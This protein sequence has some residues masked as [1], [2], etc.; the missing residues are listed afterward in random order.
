MLFETLTSEK[1]WDL[2]T[3]RADTKSLVGALSLRRAALGS[4]PDSWS[5]VALSSPPITSQHTQRCAF[6]R[7]GLLPAWQSIG[8]ASPP[9]HAGIQIVRPRAPSG[10]ESFEMCSSYIRPPPNL[11]VTNGLRE[12]ITSA[13]MGEREAKT[14][15]ERGQTFF[16][17]RGVTFSPRPSDRS[18][19]LARPLFFIDYSLNA[20][21]CWLMGLYH[22]RHGLEHVLAVDQPGR[23]SRARRDGPSSRWRADA[24]NRAWARSYRFSRRACAVHGYHIAQVRAESP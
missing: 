11:S 23:S 12:K 21:T 19:A 6:Y 5:C 7:L 16:L 3:H 8:K 22:L 4:L 18:C 2:A 9:R 1:A 14:P 10:T 13:M 20:F 17:S 15:A 24:R